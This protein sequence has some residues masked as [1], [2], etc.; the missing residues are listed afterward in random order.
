[1]KV[2]PNPA[3]DHLRIES[4]EMIRMISLYDISGKLLISVVPEEENKSVLSL[5]GL[6]PGTYVLRLEGQA[7]NRILKVVKN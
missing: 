2:Y 5:Q 6:T 1:L 4:R 7:T 3:T